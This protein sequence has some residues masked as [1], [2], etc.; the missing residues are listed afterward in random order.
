[1]SKQIAT[2]PLLMMKVKMP[3][4]HADVLQRPHLLDKLRAR[5]HEVL[6]LI[7]APAGF[8][9]TTLAY[10]WAQ[11]MACPVAWLA[12]DERDN[13][14][15]R[16]WT[17]LVGALQTLSPDLGQGALEVLLSPTGEQDVGL[18][19]LLNEI[20]DLSEDIVL[21]LDDYHLIEAETIDQ[22]IQFF[23]E[24]LPP[25]LHLV[26]SS[27]SEPNL[28]LARLRARRQLLELTAADLRFSQD[29]MAEFFT[30]L[31][32]FDL[33]EQQL[34]ALSQRTEGWIA[35]LQMT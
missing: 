30:T 11:A 12:I 34:N 23:V 9:K 19:I 21:I 2:E 4:I 1:M 32:D 17:Y 3:R 35:G 16:F 14:P 18:T 6:T 26:I 15:K 7:T 20:A 8:G 28:P 5:R 13:D 10:L 33:T 27:R 24:N 29:E 22:G 25:Q 31:G